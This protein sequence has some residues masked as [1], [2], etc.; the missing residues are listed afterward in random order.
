MRDEFATDKE[1]ELGALFNYP[2]GGKW[3][4]FGKKSTPIDL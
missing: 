2:G 3:G 4:I 1:M